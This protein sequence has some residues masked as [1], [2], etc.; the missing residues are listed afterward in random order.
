MMI[1]S[2]QHVARTEICSDGCSLRTSCFS[3][4]TCAPNASRAGCR[5]NQC[6][7]AGTDKVVTLY[8][9]LAT[10]AVAVPV[11]RQ[12][13][14]IYMNQRPIPRRLRRWTCHA[15]GQSNHHITKAQAT[16]VV[17]RHSASVGTKLA[18]S[19]SNSAIGH[20]TALQNGIFTSSP[21]T[22]ART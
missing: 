4:V 16:G 17:P 12:R 19:C 2:S 10:T 1:L 15:L 7:T 6:H 14:C 3:E 9:L 13:T 22:M 11:G 5:C 20:S 18:T 21:S 8:A